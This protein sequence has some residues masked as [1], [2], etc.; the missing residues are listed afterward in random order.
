MGI[1]TLFI[2][3]LGRCIRRTAALLISF[4]PRFETVCGAKISG[5]MSNLAQ[6]I[7]KDL[8]KIPGG[9]VLS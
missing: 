7:T 9:T 3:A 8:F 6:A 5:S 1:F 2:V 4:I